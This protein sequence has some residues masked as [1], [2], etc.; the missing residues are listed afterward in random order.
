[1]NITH[2]SKCSAKVDLKMCK[3]YIKQKKVK[4]IVFYFLFKK[5]KLLFKSNKFYESVLNVF[6]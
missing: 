2:T 4:E 5:K 6:E 1:M 3:N